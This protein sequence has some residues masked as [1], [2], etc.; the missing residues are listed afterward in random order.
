MAESSTVQAPTAGSS[1]SEA[2]SAPDAAPRALPEWSPPFIVGQPPAS[3]VPIVPPGPA[4]PPAPFAFTWGS[5]GLDSEDA[6]RAAFRSLSEGGPQGDEASTDTDTDADTVTDTGPALAR[7]SFTPVS[8]ATPVIPR[9][10]IAP[11]TAPAG[12]DERP[13][14]SPTP[15]PTTGLDDELWSALTGDEPAATDARA[16][17]NASAGAVAPAATDSPLAATPGEAAP[18]SVPAEHER[19]DQ[20]FPF[21]EVRGEAGPGNFETATAATAASVA[22]SAANRRAPFPAFAAARGDDPFGR[23]DDQGAEPVD[24]LLAALGSGAARPSDGGDHGGGSGA[25]SSGGGFGTPPSGGPPEGTAYDPFGDGFDDD[26]AAEDGP[27]DGD[28]AGDNRAGDDRA[29]ED[30]SDDGLGAL[31]LTFDDGDDEPA[32]AAE[33]ESPIAREIAETGYFWNLTPDPTAPDP[34]A[35]PS[36]TGGATTVP[37]PFGPP[38]PFADDLDESTQ[39]DAEPEPE[40]VVPEP[41]WPFEPAPTASEP[42]AATMFDPPE[43]ADV[44]SPATTMFDPPETADVEPPET[45]MFKPPETAVFEPPATDAFEPPATAAPTVDPI[46]HGTTDSTHTDPLAALFGTAAVPAGPASPQARPAPAAPFPADGAFAGAAAGAAVA[47]GSAPVSRAVAPAE[48]PASTAPRPAGAG[49]AGRGTSAG[50]GGGSRPGGGRT[51]RTLLWIAAGLVV[52]LVLAGLFYVGTLLS[53][54]GGEA[55]GPSAAPVETE[56]PVAEPTAVQPVGVHAWNTLFG[57][58]CI[59]PFA[60]VWEEEFTVV[61]CAAP[62]AAQLVYRGE[63]AGDAAAAFPGEAEVAA[64]ATAMCTADGVIDVALVAGIPDLQVQAAFPANEEQWAE[65]ERTVYCFANRM[66]GEPLTGPIAG[67]GPTA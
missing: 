29:N 43:T 17:T 22:E 19:G 56:T 63:L 49:G 9:H 37:S 51:T 40:P 6:I 52:C 14:S 15:T 58:E 4:T 23:P 20:G 59:E 27:A 61:D 24:D 33:T 67:P 38:S 39:F 31:G 66:G 30:A 62:H 18:S 5:E 36:V 35:D 48:S 57:G 1:T 12:W 55:A 46:A 41:A 21:I 10:P 16:A 32:P 53:A 7:Q 45:M 25:G 26:G 54:G 50:S 65:G 13:T 11:T 42:P 28:R 8:D 3:A 44:E 47:G 64:Q 34:K 2:P 60:S